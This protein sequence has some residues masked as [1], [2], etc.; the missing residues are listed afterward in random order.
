MMGKIEAIC[1][2]ARKGERKRPVPKALLVENSGIV[3]DAHAGAWHRQVSLLASENVDAVRRSGMPELKAGDFAENLLVSGVGFPALGGSAS[4]AESGLGLGS[5][6]TLGETAE[7]TITQIGKTCHNPCIIQ[8]QTGDCIMPRLG[9]FARVIRG[10]PITNGDTV[11]VVE[12]VPRSVF[13]AVVLTISDRCSRNEAVDTAGPAVARLLA[14]QLKA[15]IYKTEILPDDRT[16]IA[17]RLK[18]YC[19]GHSIDIVVTAGGT[20]FAP[21]DITP[22]AVDEVIDRPTPG[23]DEAMRRESGKKTPHAMLSRGV[24]GIRGATLI[25]SLPGSERAAVENLQVIIPALS[26]GLSKLRG[27]PSDCGPRREAC[28]SSARETT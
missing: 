25:V 11:N 12:L 18:H 2:S 16:C 6:L 13:Q 20:G 21:R 15:H 3:G 24:S 17:E 14:E 7:L 22:E 26:H 28:P 10:G 19:D 23:L 1:I 5:R 8:K 4:L 9:L 27:D